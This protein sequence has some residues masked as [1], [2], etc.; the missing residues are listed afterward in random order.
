MKGGTCPYAG[1]GTQTATLM[2]GSRRR[3]GR[4]IKKR[5]VIRGGEGDEAS[6]EIIVSPQPSQQSPQQPTCDCANKPT[7]TSTQP[8][9][10]SWFAGLIGGRRTRR[11]KRGSGKGCSRRRRR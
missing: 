11:R 9:Q 4:N 5:R 7:G 6:N 2:G 3:R 1:T 8:T 10:K